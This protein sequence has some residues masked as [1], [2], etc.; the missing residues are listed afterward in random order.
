MSQTVNPQ[1][2]LKVIEETRR[3]INR[4]L[5]EVSRLAES[6]LPPSEFYAEMLKRVLSAMAAPAGAVWTRTQ[7]GNL[8]LA[9]QINMREI[10]LDKS[11]EG[12]LAH[13]ELLR[14]AVLQPQ[15]LH[16]LPHS[17]AGPVEEG[18][19][20][21]ANPTDY[22]LLLAPILLNNQVAGF[23]EVW[24][25]PD[26][27]FSAVPGFLQFMS[28]MADLAARYGRNQLMGQMVGQQ[29]VW[30][31]LEAF[32]RQIHASLKP[33]EVAYLVANE[34]RRLVD[35]DRLTVGVRYGK[36]TRVESVSGCDIV[37]KRSNLVV[38]MRR[39]FNAVLAWG[40]K[41]V[42]AG[43]KD[44]SLPPKVLS[45]LDA[46]L[47]ESNSKLLVVLPLV[48]EREK[49]SKKPV[50]TALLM[51]CFE[52]PAEPQQLVARLEVVGRHSVS[53]LYNAVEYR[54]IP[55]RFV[56]LPLAK[57][58]DGLGG[59]GRVILT[60]IMVLLLSLGCLMALVPYP[61]KMDAKGQLLPKTRQHLFMPEPA[62]VQ[63]IHVKP[64]DQLPADF[65]V[66][67]AYSPQV[68]S[69]MHSLTTARNSFENLVRLARN[70]LQ[71][72]QD[73]S[74]RADLRFK[75]LDYE[76]D[77]DLKQAEL[78]SLRK[79]INA[80]EGEF[81]RFTIRTP[82]FTPTENAR[83]DAYRRANNLP[84]GDKGRWTVL[85][86]E[87]Y[88]TLAGRTFDPTQPLLRLGDKESGWE[89]ELKLPQKHMH[90]IL[91]A[92]EREHVDVLEVDLLVR[93]DPTRVFKGRLHK[94]RIGGEATPQKDDNNEAEPVVTAYVSIDDEDIP[95]DKRL[96]RELLTAGTEVLS[97]VRCGDAPMGYSLFY[98]VWEFFCEKVLFSF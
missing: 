22:L 65:S 73:R 38:L 44:E 48:D 29:Q 20:A 77:R 31:Q 15:P 83:R 24:Q 33:M 13:D 63:A 46:Y 9:F 66:L 17:G 35:C 91:S 14:Q 75:L 96:P 42:Y 95:E 8:Q 60:L 86:P 41:L 2:D 51:E 94:D 76:K 58:Q 18:K 21:A 68:D 69:K 34:G 98:G 45:A 19:P 37:E 50:R 32:A 70:E 80:V 1:V 92:Y 28:T 64:G 55:M 90:Q 82:A 12:K 6:E 25:S 11:D 56:W 61:L 93:S 88:E 40:E 39:L 3:H 87:V 16:L 84:L 72:E 30:T 7:H 78:D 74:K 97:K 89:V 27:P 85:T 59:K 52:P 71:R 36:K 79:G 4:L 57:L 43:V 54:R 26:R 10:G 62:K 47:A 49:E 23:L 81:G 5:E 67:T 53:A